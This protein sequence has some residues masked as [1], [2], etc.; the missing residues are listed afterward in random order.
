MLLPSEVQRE[1]MIKSSSETSY[2]YGFKPEERPLDLYLK[3]GFINLDKPPG[4]SSHEVVAWIKR[5]LPFVKRAG[6]AGTLDPKV[7]GVLPVGINRSTRILRYFQLAGKEYVCV[8]ELSKPV[9]EEKLKKVMGEFVGPIYQRPPLKSAVKKRLRIRHVYYLKI[10][11]VE[12]PY[13]LFIAGVEA[14]TYIRKLCHDIG[15][16]LGVRA[17]MLELRRTKV[18]RMNEQGSV[19]MHDL[20]D[21]YHFWRE[22]G[23]EDLLRKA[24]MPV[25]RALEHLPKVWVNDGAVNALCYGADLAAPGVVKLHSGIKVGD[26][27]GVYTLKDELIG[28]GK[29]LKTSEQI[30]EARK[31]L[32]VDM[33]RIIMARDTYPKMWG[34]R[35]TTTR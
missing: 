1:V 33:L 4:P 13:V 26:V 19:K 9:S 6:H 3:Y 12:M 14:G 20:V 25:D 8:M 30:L 16:L 2:D 11:E 18:G 35:S 28:I 24:I 29:A 27:V 5:L 10:L 15:L 32:V 7:T 23:R 31:G 34:R 22:D 21:A 17:S